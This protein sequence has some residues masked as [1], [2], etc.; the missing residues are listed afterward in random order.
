MLMSTYLLPFY[1]APE[2]RLMAATNR[3]AE[4]SRRI[5]EC[6]QE[7]GVEAIVETSEHEGIIHARVKE[8]T[9][10]LQVL[11][12]VTDRIAT[13]SGHGA[14]APE[15]ARSHLIGAAVRPTLN[16]RAAAGQGSTEEVSGVRE[17]QARREEETK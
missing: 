5:Q 7:A 9:G 13:P 17:R 3:I 2:I 16:V 4:L 1:L 10:T 6:L 11:A 15:M 8:K 12:Q 14:V